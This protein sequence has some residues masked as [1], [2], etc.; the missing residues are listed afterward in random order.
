[1][2]LRVDKEKGYID[3]SKRRVSP[4]DVAACDERFSKSKMVHSIMRHV[5]ETTGQDV[6]ELY[7][8]VAWPLYKAYGHAFDAFKVL[9]LSC[10][11]CLLR[12]GRQDI[13][14][15]DVR[16]VV[17]PCKFEYAAPVTVLQILDECCELSTSGLLTICD[18]VQQTMVQDPDAIFRKLQDDFNEGKPIEVLTPAVK[19]A[20]VKN[21]K[22][23]M[24]PQPLK[25]RADVE[26]T[27]YSYD[28]VLHIQ[29]QRR[30]CTSLSA[31]HSRYQLSHAMTW[32]VASGL[33]ANCSAMHRMLCGQQR[34]RAQKTV[35][36]K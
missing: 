14:V 4:E 24:T 31:L 28:G 15:S 16:S 27:C 34:R 25:I 10:R 17:G 1:M 29:V 8:S 11:Q 19:E 20:I 21:I 3:L 9:L 7:K 18:F 23:R 30:S 33:R 13:P 35:Q 12:H 2:V 6:E 36:S 32:L 5:A 22:R 26:L